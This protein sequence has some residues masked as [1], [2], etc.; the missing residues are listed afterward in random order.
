MSV[1]LCPVC[2]GKGM[3]R[4]TFYPDIPQ[5]MTGTPEWVTCRA[6]GGIGV[7]RDVVPVVADRDYPKR[8][9]PEKHIKWEDNS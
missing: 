8:F 9:F 1:H 4:S 6:C 7:F 3:V 2:S 5:Y